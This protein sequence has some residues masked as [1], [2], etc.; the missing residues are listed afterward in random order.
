[1]VLAAVSLIAFIGVQR[2][3]YR[4]AVDI[5]ITA[6]PDECGGGL[7]FAVIGDYGI[8]GQPEADVAALV[9]SWQPAFIATVGDNN[10]PDGEA[11]SIDSN[12]GRY[13]RAYIHP[14]IGGFGS[15]AEENRFFPALGN[16]DLHT[17]GGQPYVDYFSLPFAAALSGNEQYYTVVQG[18]VQLFI[19]NSDPSEIDGRSADSVQAG[20]LRTQLAASS[21]RWKL[22]L[23]HHSPYTSS[24]T[25]SSDKEIQWPYAEWG[26]TA[27][28]SGHDHRY[29]RLEVEG[30]P[31][32]INGAGGKGLYRVGV[33]EKG[34]IVRYNQD[35]GAMRI[36]ANDV[37]INFSFFSRREDLI[38]S[39]TVSPQ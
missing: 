24:L 36:Q 4:Y 3:T 21:A 20:W 25:R 8:A 11:G 32:F 7:L 9:Q 34:S 39:Y 31:Y 22:V 17:D 37:C 23:M 28:L 27:V 5:P 18:N 15:G 12:I 35:Y 30:I 1:M 19:L 33:A 29:E 26:A 10:Y 6:R 16:H 38:D 13:Y 14:Y 2:A